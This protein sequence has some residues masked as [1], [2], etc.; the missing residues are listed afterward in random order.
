MAFVLANDWR[1]T[2]IDLTAIDLGYI[3]RQIGCRAGLGVFLIKRQWIVKRDTHAGQSGTA[4]AGRIIQQR[5]SRRI[6]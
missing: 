3:I 4:G 5:F 1:L 2:T 6:R